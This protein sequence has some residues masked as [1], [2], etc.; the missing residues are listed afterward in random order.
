M[1][2]QKRLTRHVDVAVVDRMG[3]FHDA[4]VPARVQGVFELPVRVALE[5]EP[6]GC[7]LRTFCVARRRR[8][9]RATTYR[10]ASASARAAASSSS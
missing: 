7:Q 10:R 4:P 2:R 5:I 9:A 1:Q 3:V 6:C 8:L